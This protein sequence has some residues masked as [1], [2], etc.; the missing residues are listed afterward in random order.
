M[1][2]TVESRIQTSAR[3]FVRALA[4][5]PL[6]QVWPHIYQGPYPDP[7][8]W[9]TFVARRV[10][11]SWTMRWHVGDRD[12]ATANSYV[13]RRDLLE[14]PEAAAEQ[15]VGVARVALQKRGQNPSHQHDE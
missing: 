8:V 4:R 14:D 10:G 7:Y 9:C 2:T 12:D 5:R 1:T 6:A 11:H 3:A 13:T 15:L